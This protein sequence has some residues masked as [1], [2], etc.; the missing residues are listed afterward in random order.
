MNNRLM[1]HQ[2]IGTY[3]PLNSTEN[4]SVTNFTNCPQI[5]SNSKVNIT[6]V[7]YKTDYMHGIK[8]YA[9][10]TVRGP[11]YIHCSPIRGLTFDPL[12]NFRE[13]SHVTHMHA[14]S[15]LMQSNFSSK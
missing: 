15:L 7:N 6:A 5:W 9:S 4:R 1:N 12:P 8:V 14:N 11:Q 10:I 3:Y 13:G 2:R